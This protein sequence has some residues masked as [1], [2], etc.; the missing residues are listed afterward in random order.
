MRGGGKE[1]LV[2]SNMGRS[3]FSNA[4]LSETLLQF[5][6]YRETWVFP[7]LTPLHRHDKTGT[8]QLEIDSYGTI[9]SD[10]HTIRFAWTRS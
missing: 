10:G 3:I 2:S 6:S 8:F 5:V 9:Q 1:I 4:L 7:L